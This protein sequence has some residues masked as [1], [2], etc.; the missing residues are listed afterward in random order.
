MKPHGMFLKPVV[1]GTWIVSSVGFAFGM[2]LYTLKCEAI[3]IR[4][5]TVGSGVDG[6]L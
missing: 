1:A 3:A 5:T 2:K 6:D 4:A